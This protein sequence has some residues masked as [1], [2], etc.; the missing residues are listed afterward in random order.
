MAI[1][2]EGGNQEVH[3]CISDLMALARAFPWDSLIM[4]LYTRGE[5]LRKLQ[6]M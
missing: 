3:V 5:A 2:A 4:P 1:T 6:V